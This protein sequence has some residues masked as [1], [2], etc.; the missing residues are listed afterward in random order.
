MKRLFNLWFIFFLKLPLSTLSQETPWRS[1]WCPWLYQEHR[2]L[3]QDVLE[4]AQEGS[5]PQ[6][7]GWLYE[8]VAH[9]PEQLQTSVIAYFVAKAMPFDFCQRYF[10]LGALLDPLNWAQSRR[11]FRRKIA[12]FWPSLFS[13]FFLRWARSLKPNDS[14]SQPTW[15][16][17]HNKNEA[18]V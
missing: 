12:G 16:A 15:L 3:H 10:S 14:D 7:R 5:Q 11:I 8:A 17:W 9:E 18:S 2:G 13:N 4:N 6:G 1:F